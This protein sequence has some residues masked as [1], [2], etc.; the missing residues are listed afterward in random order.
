MRSNKM[1]LA[2]ILVVFFG[3]GCMSMQV[4]AP[5][6]PIK[7]DVT[8]RLDVY[9]HVVSDI[10]NIEGIVSGKTEAAPKGGMKLNFLMAN[11][12]AEEGL[13]QDV[14]DAAIRRR[15]RRAEL[16]SWETRG[17]VGENRLGLIEQRDGGAPQQLIS[18]ENAD[19][20]VIYRAIAKKNGASLEDVQKVYAQRLQSDASAG[21]PIEV[22]NTSG[23]YVWKIK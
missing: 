18:S 9:Q 11:A 20:M 4:K 5:K 6:E 12:Y 10:D 21:T 15:D 22:M 3:T 16:V 14:E 7:V 19:R 8:M 2:A 1:A 13:S 23:S 17:A